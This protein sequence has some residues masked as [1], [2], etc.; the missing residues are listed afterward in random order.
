MPADLLPT[1]FKTETWLLNKA[2][3][4]SDENV[5]SCF[6]VFT[7]SEGPSIVPY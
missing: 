7:N 3:L 5:L 4:C 2:I 1:R 6:C